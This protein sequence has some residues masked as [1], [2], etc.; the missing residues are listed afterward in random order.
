V[1]V[2]AS[3]PELRA[4]LEGTLAWREASLGGQAIAGALE[5][6]MAVP[7]SLLQQLAGASRIVLTGAGSSYYVA[8]VAAAA[9]RERCGLP[10]VAAPLSEVLLRPEGVLSKTE[11]GRQP[12][13]VISRSGTTTE[14][15]AAASAVREAGHPTLCVTCRNGT[16]LEDVVDEVLRVPADEQAIVMTRS[17]VAMTVLLLRLVARLVPGAA[18]GTDL[19]RLPNGWATAGSL[20]A[21]ALD[22]AAGNP[23]RV[24]V[25]G[26]GAAFGLANEAVLKLTETSQ[27]PANAWEPLEFRHGP[28]SVSEPGVLVVGIIGGAGAD[29]EAPVL[30]EAGRLGATIWQPA[31]G[32][33][34]ASLDPIASLPL[35]LHPLQALAFGLAIRRGCD[36]DRPRHLSQVVVLD[37]T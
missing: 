34:L 6:A 33:G 37:D 8:Q 20:I 14:A 3:G 30:A 31:L 11:P 19:D 27:V 36:P 2:P 5:R 32:G 15:I 9:L 26:G 4:R 7:A 35:L 23:S 16:T 12:V 13:I 28:I 29:A 22:L 18:L 17:F 1:D 10:G 24:A 25:L 21:P